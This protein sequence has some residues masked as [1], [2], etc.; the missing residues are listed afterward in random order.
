MD[1]PV[2][3][4]EG[5]VVEELDGEVLVYDENNDVA[6]RLNPTAALV[7][8]SC[9][10]ERTVSDLVAVL[11][12]EHGEIVDEDM[13]MMA[14]D[15]L[16]EHDLITDGFQTREISARMLSRR[17]FFGK[18][19]LTGAAAVAAPIVY[20]MSVPAAAAASSFP[21]TPYYPSFSDRRL[22]RNVRTLR[23][24]R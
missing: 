6:C 2:A 14:L 12:A 3:R 19:G 22:K 13:V 20:S 21:Y 24:N 8:R 4:R 10:G 18:V 7:W 23:G 15:T 16:A 5:L 17:R 1:R 9:D 11:A